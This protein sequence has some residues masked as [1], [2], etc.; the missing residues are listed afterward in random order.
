M[1]FYR[2]PPVAQVEVAQ[3]AV[4][5]KSMANTINASK[6]SAAGDKNVEQSVMP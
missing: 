5:A 2:R 4:N 3:N 6:L 1:S